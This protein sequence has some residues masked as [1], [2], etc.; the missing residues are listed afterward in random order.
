MHLVH[1]KFLSNSTRLCSWLRCYLYRFRLVYHSSI[2]VVLPLTLFILCSKLFQCRLRLTLRVR[3]LFL[4]S[5]IFAWLP[6]FSLLDFLF[7]FPVLLLLP[8]RVSFC[9]CFI[10]I[11]LFAVVASFDFSNFGHVLFVKRL[12]CRCYFLR[13]C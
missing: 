3:S 8:S 7:A 1:C 10:I 2:H 13:V 4:F 9:I 12:R 11:L 6:S 5:C